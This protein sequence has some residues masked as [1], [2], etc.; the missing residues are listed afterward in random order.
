MYIIE[1]QKKAGG[2]GGKRQT[3]RHCG[4][5]REV[6]LPKMTTNLSLC[7]KKS[8]NFITALYVCTYVYHRHFSED[9]KLL[10]V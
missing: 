3:D 2:M 10:F 1:K 9:F 4:S 6:T 7:S 5:Y 8:Y